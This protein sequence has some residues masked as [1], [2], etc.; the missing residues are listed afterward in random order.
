MG[1]EFPF[2]NTDKMV[3]YFSTWPWL[4]IDGCEADDVELDPIYA[5]PVVAVRWVLCLFRGFLQGT[6]ERLWKLA[7]SALRVRK[8]MD[9]CLAASPW[10]RSRLL[11]EPGV[12]DAISN[13][14][15]TGPEWRDYF[16]QWKRLV[17]RRP[18]TPSRLRLAGVASGLTPLNEAYRRCTPISEQCWGVHSETHMNSCLTCCSPYEGPRGLFGCFSKEFTFQRCCNVETTV[19]SLVD[20]SDI[21]LVKAL[22]PSSVKTG[23]AHRL[24]QLLFTAVP[25]SW[26]EMQAEIRRPCE[27]RTRHPAIAASAGAAGAADAA[28]AGAGDVESEL[29]AWAKEVDAWLRSGKEPQ[30]IFHAA[31]MY[32][33]A[34]SCTVMDDWTAIAPTADAPDGPELLF[35]AGALCEPGVEWH[36]GDCCHELG[37][38]TRQRR[39]VRGRFVQLPCD[40][41]AKERHYAAVLGTYAMLNAR[42]APEASPGCPPSRVDAVAVLLGHPGLISVGHALHDFAFLGNVLRVAARGGFRAVASEVHVLPSKWY[43]RSWNNEAK[44]LEWRVPFKSFRGRLMPL[45]Q[46]FLDASLRFAEEAEGIKVVVH[47]SVTFEGLGCVRCYPAAVQQWRFMGG[48]A[49]FWNTYRA[50]MLN[51]CGIRDV[52]VLPFRRKI[53]VLQ[54]TRFIRSL[55]NVADVVAAVLRNA[56]PGWTAQVAVMGEMEPCDQLR[57][58]HDA[59][60]LVSVSGG[61]PYIAV[62]MPEQ[63]AVIVVDAN[64]IERHNASNM[65]DSVPEGVWERYEEQAHRRCAGRPLYRSRGRPE[66]SATDQIFDVANARNLWYTSLNNATCLEIPGSD[67]LSAWTMGVIK[68]DAEAIGRVVAASIDAHLS[69]FLPAEA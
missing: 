40:R 23:K 25:A 53:L 35:E 17:S 44:S 65:R 38:V 4:V 29:N 36:E 50:H 51:I 10:G 67:C 64:T 45:A 20:G 32:V 33:S 2:E 27:A 48:D 28:D 62:A 39:S 43:L 15:E 13:L 34:P 12:W 57:A 58:A 21:A 55:A 8:L 3:N 68:A 61:E 6:Q 47:E 26:P 22:E 1:M 60:V 56:P 19:P 66:F 5:W 11:T 37:A 59:S 41:R 42:Q 16:R 31:D 52:P 54:R 24:D 46:L 14:T 9:S 49:D 69:R 7:W 30:R 63:S 18:L